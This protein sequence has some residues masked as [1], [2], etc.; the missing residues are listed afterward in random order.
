M[1][2]IQVTRLD[3]S[4]L[5]ISAELVELLEAVP[6]TVITLTT[7]RKLVVREDVAEVVQR[8]KEY[9]RSVYGAALP[10]GGVED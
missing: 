8:I 10:G 2:V 4:E 1:T 6:D 9:R 3:G 7:G 5:V